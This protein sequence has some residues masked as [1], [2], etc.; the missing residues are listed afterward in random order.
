MT[1]NAEE[2]LANFNFDIN[3]I[4]VACLLGGTDRKHDSITRQRFV[5]VR[6]YVVVI[7]A[8]I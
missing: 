7:N 4:L 6:V 5:L 1:F 8:Y 3:R 2:T